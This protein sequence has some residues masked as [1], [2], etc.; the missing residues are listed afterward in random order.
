MCPY[1]SHTGSPMV[2]CVCPRPARPQPTYL[3]L[4]VLQIQHPEALEGRHGHR[5]SAQ[6]AADKAKV[7]QA[8]GQLRGHGAG[9]GKGHLPGVELCLL[10]GRHGRPDGVRRGQV[11]LTGAGVHLPQ[12]SK[13]FFKLLGVGLRQKG[14]RYFCVIHHSEVARICK[15]PGFQSAKVYDAAT[16]LPRECQRP[17]AASSSVS[18]HILRSGTAQTPVQCC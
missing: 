2:V 13:P 17:A 18:S 3:Q 6:V 1:A 15:V 5:E 9:G 8:R 11:D 4:V 16:P 7:F 12:C 10:G 14:S